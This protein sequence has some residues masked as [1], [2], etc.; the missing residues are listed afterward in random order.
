MESV[1]RRFRQVVSVL[2]CAAL[3]AT[4]CASAGGP[5]VSNT[6]QPGSKVADPAVVAEYAQQLAPGTTVRVQ[7]ASGPTIR[8][9]L[10]KA[11][12]QAIVVQPR[13]RIPEPA[14][15]IPAAEIVGI[16]PES[17][18]GSNVVAKAIVAGVAAGAGA[19]L[20]VFLVLVSIYD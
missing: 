20:A 13:T 17:G 14:V 16:T 19:A 18:S 2:V 1:M 9:T 6:P 7:R 3:T 8:G 5:R 15:E 4:G 12:A 10:M 11:T